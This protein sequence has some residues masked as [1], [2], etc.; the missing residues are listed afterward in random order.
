MT[1][2]SGTRLA[3]E[4]SA[5]GFEG[6]LQLARDKG[7][8]D[9]PLSD[10]VVEAV[11]ADTRERS[12]LWAGWR[13]LRNI[14]NACHKVSR[15]KQLEPW[16]LVAP[17][18]LLANDGQLPIETLRHRVHLYGGELLRLI[19]L[20]QSYVLFDR[21]TAEA[22]QQLPEQTAPE[23]QIYYDHWKEA[24]GVLEQLVT[25]FVTHLRVLVDAVSAM[26]N[27]A[28]LDWS[29]ETEP[30]RDMLATRAQEMGNFV[31]RWKEENVLRVEIKQEE[32]PEEEEEEEEQAQQQPL[33][34]SWI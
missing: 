8:T 25:R 31:A 22:L 29:N 23:H 32:Y 6:Y 21:A 14:L 16:R 27:S 12:F 18:I 19:R 34:E 20:M 7:Y 30:F 24:T 1:L 28:A 2:W 15:L 9:A 17:E 10:R 13:T 11:M 5:A 3:E 33:M 4:M 26:K